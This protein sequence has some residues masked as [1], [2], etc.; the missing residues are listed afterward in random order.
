MSILKELEAKHGGRHKASKENKYGHRHQGGDRFTVN[1]Y[2]EAYLPNIPKD[3][4]VVLEI[5][6]FTGTGLRVWSDYYPNARII[7][8]DHCPEDV[9]DPGRAEVHYFDQLKPEGLEEILQGD[10]V[11]LAIDDGLHRAFCQV[12]TFKY[13]Q[14]FLNENAIYIIEDISSLAY[15]HFEGWIDNCEKFITGGKMAIVRYPSK[16]VTVAGEELLK[17]YR[18]EFK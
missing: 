13:V 16:G 8:L 11:D 7:G 3:P 9:V 12:N 17:K 5:G 2:D 1:N 6:V 10:K 14:P 15:P 18:K 4:K